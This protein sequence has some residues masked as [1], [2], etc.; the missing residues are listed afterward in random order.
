MNRR[1]AVAAGLLLLLSMRAPAQSN[2]AATKDLIDKLMARI[3][4][5]EKRVAELEGERG[6]HTAAVPSAA[7]PP[8]QT[9]P[10]QAAAPAPGH[11]HDQ[12]PGPQMP[13]P[14]PAEP[15]Y[16]NLKI[17]GFGDVDFSATD[18]RGPAV[19]FSPQTL[20]LPHSGFEL[21]QLTLHLISSLSA[22]V[23]FFGEL[24]FTARA[25]AGTGSP[26][27]PGYNPEVE[28]LII[29]YDVNDYFKAS[30]G[31]YHTP[32]NY[33]NTAFH[34]GAWLQTTIS[35]P[36]MIEFGGSF[37]PVHFI[38]ALAEG[39]LPAGG[40]NFNYNAGLGNGRGQVL[41]RGGDA[42]DINNNRAWLFNGFVRPDFLYGL[43]VGGSV[44]RDELDPTTGPV[45]R[46]WIQSAHIVWTKETP[47]FL[48]EF[49]NV[50]NHPLF[51]GPTANSQAWYVQSAYRLPWFG[52][53]LKPYER[54]EQ[55]HVPRAD[56]DFRGI[57]PT[58]T[59]TTS[60]L[61]WDFS[62]LAAFK[63]EYRYYWRRDLA[64]IRGV[65]GQ[66]AFTF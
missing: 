5:L 43:Q 33:W 26:P 59:A 19:G 7:A 16:P 29:R 66:V 28:R 58:F 54:V 46:E 1:F 61:R 30:F 17:A 41:S 51:G 31:R 25:D 39:V 14:V 57:V 55:I 3:D 12:A 2:D 24:T 49:A 62:P 27:A 18:Q 20:L 47:E 50:S 60:G 36:E 11:V 45:A 40:L 52:R 8:V 6:T 23:N 37:L 65:F 4:S 10:V 48:A 34:H 42:G 38:G 53:E 44:Y 13:E 35:R 9:P 21:G 22:K 56:A 64:P 63:F 15:V 32:I